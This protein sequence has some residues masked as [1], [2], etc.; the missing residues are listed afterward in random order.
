[1]EYSVYI[2]NSYIN[3]CI[4]YYIYFNLPISSYCRFPPMQGFDN[5]TNPNVCNSFPSLRAT[6]MR[7]DAGVTLSTRS[8]LTLDAIFFQTSACMPTISKPI[9]INF[10][11]LFL[12]FYR[13]F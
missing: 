8:V 4:L 11:C 7:I 2:S 9:K 13:P 5:G 12:Y 3:L 1:M 6:C 10:S